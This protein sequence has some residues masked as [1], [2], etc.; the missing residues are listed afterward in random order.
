MFMEGLLMYL[1]YNGDYCLVGIGVNVFVVKD[2]KYDFILLWLVL[3]WVQDV[4]DEYNVKCYFSFWGVDVCEE[5]FLLMLK[6]M[7]DR[8]CRLEQY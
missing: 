3:N 2:Y 8:I 4:L 7:E 1:G 5:F 6:D